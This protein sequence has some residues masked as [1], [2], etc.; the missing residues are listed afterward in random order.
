MRD[1]LDILYGRAV[2]NENRQ[3]F[4]N[5]IM[6]ARRVVEN[7][8]PGYEFEAI[9]PASIV[10][11]MKLGNLTI[12]MSNGDC[13]IPLLKKSIVDTSWKSSLSSFFG[14]NEPQPVVNECE[15]EDYFIGGSTTTADGDVFD[16]EGINPGTREMISVLGRAASSNQAIDCYIVTHPI[17]LRIAGKKL[18]NVP[19]A[20]DVDHPL[21]FLVVS[22]VSQRMAVIYKGYTTPI[23][24]TRMI[25]EAV[26]AEKF[27]LSV[28]F[29]ASQLKKYKYDELAKLLQSTLDLYHSFVGVIESKFDK[30]EISY[31]RAINSSKSLL[32]DTISSM[33]EIVSNEN[34][35]LKCTPQELQQ[36]AKIMSDVVQKLA[37]TAKSLEENVVLSESVQEMI[38]VLDFFKEQSKYLVKKMN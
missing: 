34:I 37:E 28:S 3:M 24:L 19:E 5:D 31:T 13:K 6:S 36:K 8:L 2:N 16:I 27:Q 18:K 1:K 35:G 33:L 4:S 20:V 7:L 23:N 26:E 11:N 30:T 29:V 12:K 38:Q 17:L 32:K 21:V 14:K 9:L 10:N 22:G 15:V 25:A